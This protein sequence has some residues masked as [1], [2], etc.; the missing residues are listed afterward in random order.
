MVKQLAIYGRN[1]THTASV[2]WFDFGFGEA[3]QTYAY[4]CLIVDPSNIVDV[5]FISQNHMFKWSIVYV[6][7]PCI[8]IITY[9]HTLTMYVGYL[10][11]TKRFACQS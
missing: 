8:Y 2:S 1:T 4:N 10:F 5:D 3:R 6:N 11:V 9:I 7:W